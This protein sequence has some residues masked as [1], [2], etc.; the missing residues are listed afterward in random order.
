MPDQAT[1]AYRNLQVANAGRAA[2]LVAGSLG[3]YLSSGDLLSGFNLWSTR[4]VAVVQNAGQR[5]VQ[6]AER[7]YLTTREVARAPGTPTW[8]PQPVVPEQ[9]VTSLY[10]TAG[11]TLQQADTY[12]IGLK[13]ARVQAAGVAI[14]HTM[15]AG[16]NST[17][18]SAKADQA[19]IGAVYLTKADDRVCHWCLMLASRGPVYKGHS[20]DESDRLFT[21]P[22]TAKVHDNCRCVLRTVYSED[23]PLLADARELYARWLDATKDPETGR[24]LSG[25]NAINAWRRDIYR[26]RSLAA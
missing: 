25:R 1:E 4:A 6:L 20:F 5:A 15:N 19:A 9:V 22:G 11:Q 24:R 7:E 18:A 26:Q 12:Q 10:A 14:R 21:G 13:R 16:R 8:T 2:A 3:A 17:I 23:A